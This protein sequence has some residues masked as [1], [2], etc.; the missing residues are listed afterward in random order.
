MEKT[1]DNDDILFRSDLLKT[2]LSRAG[3]YIIGII[4]AYILPYLFQEGFSGMLD[5]ITWDTIKQVSI[6]III[7]L[8]AE[9]GLRYL[10]YEISRMRA[11]SDLRDKAIILPPGVTLKDV[12]PFAVTEYVIT[13]RY[14]HNSSG[15]LDLTREE[16]ATVLGGNYTMQFFKFDILDSFPK[17]TETDIQDTSKTNIIF[18][19]NSKSDLKKTSTGWSKE[20][21]TIYYITHYDKV[22]GPKT[23]NKLIY[24]LAVKASDYIPKVDIDKES[25]EQVSEK[26][27]LEVKDITIKVELP[28]DIIISDLDFQATGKSNVQLHGL[29]SAI[30][31][32]NRFEKNVGKRSFS[33]KIDS[34]VPDVRY[35]FTWKWNKPL[36]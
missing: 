30:K 22:I 2:I 25:L 14:T 8:L 20:N 21:N 3:S 12:I 31:K 34:P 7:V 6:S 24:D 13:Y 1:L 5:N 10:L 23:N 29:A 36:K 16:S 27:I 9:A 4:T 32:N 11:N 18:N 15:G 19:T 35:G 28:E 17:F 33:I 26:V